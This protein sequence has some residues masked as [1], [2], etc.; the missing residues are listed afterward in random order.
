MCVCVCD[1]Q[2][3]LDELLLLA[4]S[5]LHEVLQ[6]SHAFVFLLDAPRKELWTNFTAPQ[7]LELASVRCVLEATTAC[8]YCSSAS[9]LA[10][11]AETVLA[12]S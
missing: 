12:S 6:T 10:W 7:T 4:R 9:T 3:D 11:H 1:R 8:N 2:D 5:A